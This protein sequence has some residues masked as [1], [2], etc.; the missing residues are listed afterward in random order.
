MAHSQTD[1]E[2][3]ILNPVGF[4]TPGQVEE[5]IAEISNPV[6]SNVVFEGLGGGLRELS[7]ASRISS[8]VYATHRTDIVSIGTSSKSPSFSAILAHAPKSI[9]YVTPVVT[10]VY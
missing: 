5:I 2:I 9:F 1:P 3:H 4:V 7:D 6:D 10:H 8:Y